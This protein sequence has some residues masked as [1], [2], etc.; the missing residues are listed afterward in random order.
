MSQSVH[1]P[2]YLADFYY[3]GTL[4]LQCIKQSATI[5][6]CLLCVNRIPGSDA[7]NKAT[8]LSFRRNFT[9]CLDFLP[10]IFRTYRASVRAIQYHLDALLP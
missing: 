8:D 9:M 4:I 2:R 3:R 5:R 6:N 1:H 10:V 7:G